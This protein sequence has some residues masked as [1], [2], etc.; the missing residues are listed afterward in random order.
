[1]IKIYLILFIALL[2]CG[3]K[4]KDEEVNISNKLIVEQEGIQ[5]FLLSEKELKILSK[6]KAVNKY[7]EPFKEERFVLDD[8][9]GEFR[10]SLNNFYSREKRQEESI[11]IDEL[12]WEKDQEN[13]I[14]VW[15]E[16]KEGKSMP[17]EVY[18]WEKGSEF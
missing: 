12:T 10:I 16:V 17:I 14:T 2:S 3:K 9:Q 8:A 15:Y 11:L 18:S 13:W 4:T 5:K 6:L 1:M 7:G